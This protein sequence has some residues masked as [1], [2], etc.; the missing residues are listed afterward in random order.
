MIAKKKVIL[1]CFLFEKL[2]SINKNNQYIM[3]SEVLNRYDELKC[4]CK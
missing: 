4:K 2:L 1:S 3:F